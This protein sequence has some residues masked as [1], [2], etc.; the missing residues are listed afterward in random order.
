MRSLRK[1]EQFIDR[2]SGAFGWLAGWLCI[3]MLAVVFVDV[4]AR[5]LFESGSIAMQEL[6]WHLF[7]AVFLLG[8]AYTMRENANVRVDVLYEKMSKRKQAAVDIFGTVFFVIP[9][10][11]LILYSAFDFVAYSY[12]VREVSNDPGGLP[13]RFAFKALLPFGYFLVLI[14]S[15]AVISRNI[16]LLAG[17]PVES[18]NSKPVYTEKL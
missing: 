11:T 4:I 3:L 5:Y 8:A 7:A 6:E 14:Q 9:M 17:D 15:F 12:A 16:R 13:Y 18:N 2:I 10:C 1:F